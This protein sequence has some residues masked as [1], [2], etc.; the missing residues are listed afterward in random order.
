[1]ARQKADRGERCIRVV[2]D[3]WFGRGVR[4]RK[5]SIARTIDILASQTLDDLHWAI[6]GAFDRHDEH[7]YRFSFGSDRPYDR[8]ADVIEGDEPFGEP[9]LSPRVASNVLMGNLNIGPKSKFFYLF[10]FGD[11][12]WHRITVVDVDAPYDPNQ[13]YPKVIKWKGKSPEQYSND[14]DGW[15]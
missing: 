10:D 14:G 8:K 6:Y 7:L 13:I 9:S 15:L 2:V 5:G 3:V 1:M 12:W 11:D 4:F